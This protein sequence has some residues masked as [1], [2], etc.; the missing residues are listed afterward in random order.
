V[1]AQ[2]QQAAEL[3]RQ[4]KGDNYIFGLGCLGRLG[5][6]A[7]PLGRRAAVVISGVG[8]DWARSLHESVLE[9][10][11]AAGVEIVGALIPGAA[12]NAPREDVIRIKEALKARQPELV[13]SVGGGSGI[14]A[15]KAAL[16][17]LALEDLHPDIDAYFGVN[18]VS[19]RLQVSGRSLLPLVA[20]QLAASSSA[21]LTKYSNVTNMGAGQK[22]LIVDD[23]ITP[24]RA[25]FDYALTTSMSRDF[26]MDGALDGVS[27]SL[28]VY[29]G[30]ARSGLAKVEPVALLGIELIVGSLQR[31]IDSPGDLEAREALGL[32]TDLGGYSVMIGGTNGAHLTSFSL[33]DLLAHGRACALMNPYY[34]VFFAPAIEDRVRKVGEIYQ[35]AGF[36][37]TNL[38]G[39]HGRDL[40]L[41][42]ADA[43][44]ELSRAV[45]FPTRLLDVP[46]FTDAH[47]ARCLGAAKN[48]KLEM[49]LKNMPVPLSAETVDEYMGP[50]LEA[51]K[52]GDFGL[53]RNMPTQ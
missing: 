46:G 4:L 2:K 9:S 16:A 29:Y 42:V 7:A 48:P 45:G 49:K 39:L 31:A 38:T 44:L 27:H 35:R 21:H 37:K 47:I 51:A 3:L 30:A 15:V 41:A 11:G 24:P 18:E 6:L 50:I 20:V 33:V 52:T 53:I 19:K 1:S 26:T 14:D 5:A 8:K 28:E 12:P 34:T 22:L 13:V 32:G 36:G 43:M 40:G 25:L 23:A 17:L 10:L